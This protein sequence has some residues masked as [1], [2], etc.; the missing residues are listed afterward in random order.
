MLI[1]AAGLM[2]TVP[3]CTD[4]PRN[5]SGWEHTAGGL[6]TRHATLVVARNGA[7]ETRVTIRKA[8]TFGIAADQPGWIDVARG[9]GKPLRVALRGPGVACAKI[10]KIVYYQLQPGTYR[11]TMGKL[12]APQVKLMLVYGARA[13][14][15]A[16]RAR[17]G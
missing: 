4:L 12:Q 15:F 17:V 7:A 8:G 3:P 2:L 6:D 13:R 5:L 14:G 1:L 16:R 9:T 11:V 10:E